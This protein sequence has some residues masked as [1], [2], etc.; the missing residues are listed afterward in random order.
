MPFV[1]RLLIMGGPGTGKTHQIV[2][3]C[4][5]LAERKK[6]MWVL[7]LEDKVEA[8]LSNQGGIPKNMHLKV[9]LSWEEIRETIDVWKK[10]VKPGNWV[11]V[12]RMD[13]AWPMVQ[14][15][16]TQQ[17]YQEELADRMLKSAQAI[18]KTMML[19]P[20]FDQ[21]AWQVI[22]ES[23]EYVMTNILYLFRC[24][25]LLTA[26]VKTSGDDASPFETFSNVG[27]MPRGQKELAHQP[28]TALLLS[29]TTERGHLGDVSR[30]WYCTT[31]KDLPGR[32]YMDKEL[33]F[34]L[35]LQ[36]LEKYAEV[37]A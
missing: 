14:R 18:K 35:A 19:V 1:E 37:K 21:G 22:N 4:T 36:Y 2:N 27:V 13:L 33:L 26:G 8:F 5:W 20:R 10:E 15:W 34:D 32:E 12:D 3:V 29:N 11:A 28:H 25:V 6:E 31:A 30:A 23:F 16:Y 24:N 17:K 9:A 7:D